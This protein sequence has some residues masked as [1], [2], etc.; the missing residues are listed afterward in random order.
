MLGHAE[1]RDT[2]VAVATPP[3]EGGIGIVRLSGP[4]ALVV[5]D[6][7]FS[8]RSGG[9]VAS[10]KNF[11]ARYGHVRDGKRIVDEA[12]L[13]VMRAPAS[14]TGEHTVEISA[15]GGRAV[16]EAIVRLALAQGARL[17]EPGEFTKRAFLNG[18]MD[19]LQAEAVLDL[20]RARTERERGWAVSQLE[21]ALS[22][23]M[24]AWKKELAEVLSHLEA[25]VDFPDDAPAVQPLRELA[26]RLEAVRKA[27]ERAL[28]DSE[29]AFLAKEGFCAALWGRPNV[30]KSSLLNRLTRSERAIVTPYPGTTRD[31]VEETA[32]VGG[33]AVRFQ[34][35]AGVRETEHPVEREGVRRS[36]KTMAGA[37]LVLLVLDSSRPLEKED[38]ALVDEL[39]DRKAVIVM[40]KSDL[41]R[42]SDLPPT[43]LPVVETSCVTEGGTAALEE[44]LL[45]LVTGGRLEIPQEALI[46]TARQKDLLEKVS[47]ELERASAA[48]REL[49]AEMV[50]SD[51]RQA[52]DALGHVTGEVFNDDILDALFKQFCIGK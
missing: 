17:A 13:L 16:M 35:T 27:V 4:E 3:G 47:K 34:D 22:R 29:L 11:T 42:R 14:Y 37:D 7:L 31:V 19:L 52:I 1:A 32:S 21:G 38:L 8:A 41:P 28:E 43:G 51:V 44:K 18:R 24:K 12:L 39:R 40:N 45:A 23:K 2:I 46:S 48:C 25:D 50:A 49:S 6:A 5:A 26:G 33:F 20:V 9:T 30:G 10:Q 36:R 15:H